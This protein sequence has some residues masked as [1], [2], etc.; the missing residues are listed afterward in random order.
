[1]DV[2]YILLVI[3]IRNFCLFNIV[4]KKCQKKV[5][6]GLS[7]K[8]FFANEFSIL[9]QGQLVIELQYDKSSNL[10]NECE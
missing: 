3:E 2:G 9:N 10:P 5:S 6:G 1:M 8:N 4:G 7:I